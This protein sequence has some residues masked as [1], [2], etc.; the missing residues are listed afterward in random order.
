MATSSKGLILAEE[1]EVVD[2]EVQ[3][4]NNFERLNDFG[5]GSY[6]CTSATRPTGSNTWPGQVIYETDTKITYIWN[7]TLWFPIA[8]PSSVKTGAVRFNTKITNGVAFGTMVIPSMPFKCD[9]VVRADLNVGFSTAAAEVGFT[10]QRTAGAGGSLDSAAGNHEV[11]CLAT[12]WNSLASQAKLLGVT[13]P[14]TIRGLSSVSTA[15]PAGSY[16]RGSMS[17]EVFPLEA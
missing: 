10:W 16:F 2:V 15:D 12:K 6:V 4:A 5:M 7:G 1:N 17:W 13:G 14:Q 11:H 9:V 3:I 8:M